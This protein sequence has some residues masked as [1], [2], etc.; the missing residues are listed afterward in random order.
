LFIRKLVTAAAPKHPHFVIRAKPRADR[1]VRERLAAFGF[2][3]LSLRFLPGFLFLRFHPAQRLQIG[4]IA[5]VH[6]IVGF[7]AQPAPVDEEE[8]EALLRISD[9]R[10]PIGPAPFPA[11]GRPCRLKCGPLEGVR[12]TLMGVRERPQVVVSLTLL[13]RSIAVEVEPDWVAPYRQCTIR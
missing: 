12:G 9:A 6:S 4:A 13:Q 3:P 1:Q 2:S 5:G 8:L 7:A 11:I 10:L